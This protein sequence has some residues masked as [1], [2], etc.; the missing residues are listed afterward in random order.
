MLYVQS[1]LDML[2]VFIDSMTGN[3]EEVSS[4]LGS[5]SGSSPQVSL[6]W[7]AWGGLAKGRGLDKKVSRMENSYQER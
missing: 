2:T 7:Q 5:V 6:S 4:S 1:K 3:E